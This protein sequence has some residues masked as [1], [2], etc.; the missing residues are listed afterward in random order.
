MFDQFFKEYQ[1]E[2]LQLANSKAGRASL[3]I[4]GQEK[5]VKLGANFYTVF[6]GHVK[7]G[8]IWVPQF[9]TSVFCSPQYAYNLF[10]GHVNTKHDP[11]LL[12]FIAKKNYHSDPYNVFDEIF[13]GL[14]PRAYFHTNPTYASAGDGALTETSTVYATVR[15]DTSFDLV[16]DGTS[17][18]GVFVDNEKN[19][20]DYY[21]SRG[22]LPF[23]IPDLTTDEISAANV[24]LTVYGTPT[25]A[26]ADMLAMILTTQ[27]SM[28]TL[29][30]A[31]CDNL[32]LNSPAEGMSRVLI[33]SLANADAQN[34]L[35]MNATGISWIPSNGG[36]NLKLGFRTG[37]ETDNTAP[38]LGA[39]FFQARFSEHATQ[40]F[41]PQLNIT[42]APPAAG[43]M[44]MVA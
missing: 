36:G 25:G 2:L 39:N 29:A 34:T 9:K 23:V 37:R 32:T 17:A 6:Q 20:S 18:Q 42:H 31:D 21:I 8:R 40:S 33:T 3:F 11:S 14:P 30:N 28:T 35:N 26:D 1:Q 41:R 19:G 15:G 13:R 5:I 22:F 10:G 7:K 27:A 4:P 38:V 12:A 43:G 16:N 44:V 24:V